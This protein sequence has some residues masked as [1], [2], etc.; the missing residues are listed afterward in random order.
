M[1]ATQIR[2]LLQPKGILNGINMYPGEPT[3]HVHSVGIKH[4]HADEAMDIIN[5]AGGRARRVIGVGN[6]YAEYL[7]VA[8][9]EEDWK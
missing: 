1:T 8:R 2:A 5:K 7:N 9:K 4:G 6:L 3:E